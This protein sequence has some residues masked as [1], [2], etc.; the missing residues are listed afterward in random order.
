MFKFNDAETVSATGFAD[1]VMIRDL[2]GELNLEIGETFSMS[3]AMTALQ[4]IIGF[5][6][7]NTFNSLLRS[8]LIIEV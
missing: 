3:Q 5:R 7:K 8:N 6:A 2:R 4:S 1:A